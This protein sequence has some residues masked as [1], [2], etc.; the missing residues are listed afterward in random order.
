[1]LSLILNIPLQY[2]H[3]GMFSEKTC[4]KV[5]AWAQDI[6]PVL[7]EASQMKDEIFFKKLDNQK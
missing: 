6:L 3:I 7:R 1:M 5:I 4:L 2:T